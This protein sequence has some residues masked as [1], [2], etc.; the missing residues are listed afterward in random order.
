MATETLFSETQRL[1]QWWVRLLLPVITLICLFAL[2]YQVILGKPLGAN[3]PSNGMIIVATV[4]ALIITAIFL[5]FKL[6]TEVRADGI[7][8]RFY[9]LQQQY[10]AYPFTNI[11]RCYIRSYSSEKEFGG[12]GA[13]FGTLGHSMA[14]DISGN[15]GLQIETTDGEQVLIGTHKYQEF[16]AALERLGKLTP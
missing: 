6:Q 9:P 15:K 14:Y 4:F 1:K 3:P 11:K 16:S 8:E 10:R 12:W 7:Y 2:V 13:R 5:S